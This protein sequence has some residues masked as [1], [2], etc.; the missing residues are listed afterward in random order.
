MTPE[1]RET[2]KRTQEYWDDLRKTKEIAREIN[3]LLICAD[4]PANYFD[5]VTNGTDILIKISWK[6]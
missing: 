2:I 3:N 1:E 5:I 4:I 6:H